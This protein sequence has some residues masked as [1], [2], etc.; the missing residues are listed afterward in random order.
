MTVIPARSRSTSATVGGW[1]LSRT[2]A[3]ARTSASRR[4]PC[5]A[6]HAS[7]NP[8]PSPAPG[9]TATSAPAFVSFGTSSGTRATRRSPGAS[10]ARMPTIMEGRASARASWPA[11]SGHSAE[12]IVAQQRARGICSSPAVVVDDSPQPVSRLPVKQHRESPRDPLHCSPDRA[13]LAQAGEDL[14]VKGDAPALRISGSTRIVAGH[15]GQRGG[16]RHPQGGGDAETV[17]SAIA[18]SCRQRGGPRGRP[19][20]PA[21]GEVQVPPA[22]PDAALVATGRALFNDPKLSADGRLSCATCHPS[23]GHTDN[24]TYVGVEVVPDGDPRGRSTPTLWGAGTRQ[25]YSWAGT[26][27]SLEANIR[28]IIVNRM[29][30]P[31]PSPETLAAL[32]A[33]VRSLGYPPNPYLNPDGSPTAAAP[34][35]AKRGYAIFEKAGCKACHLPPTFDKKDV[36]DVDSGGK[37]KVP[38]VRAPSRSPGP[39]STT[40]GTPP[41]TRRSASCGSTCRRLGRRRSSRTAT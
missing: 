12:R 7:E 8:A 39:T 29:K 34:D 33:Y 17:G 32:V 14:A 1:T 5:S 37:F 41:W 35:A 2:S 27:P 31:E 24:K 40:G 16:L 28:G 38:V 18:C 26:A 23:N 25:A 20:H 6:Y 22:S 19:G 30:G 10:S 4:A 36:E 9:S 3:V 21:P 13:P 15:H 11:S